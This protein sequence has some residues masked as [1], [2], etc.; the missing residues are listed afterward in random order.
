MGLGTGRHWLV[1]LD[2]LWAAVQIASLEQNGTLHRWGRETDAGHGLGGIIGAEVKHQAV[3]RGFVVGFGF[4]LVRVVDVAGT[5]IAMARGVVMV[6]M[7]PRRTLVFA[8]SCLG[9]LGSFGLFHR[10]VGEEASDEG[11]HVERRRGVGLC[12]RDDLLMEMETMR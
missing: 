10:H 11:R 9:C 5:V 12:H 1:H 3:C 6:V 2:V 8:R 4:G 7:A